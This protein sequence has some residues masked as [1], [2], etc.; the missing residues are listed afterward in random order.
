MTVVAVA[1]RYT[2]AYLFYGAFFVLVIAHRGSKWTAPLRWRFLQLSGALSYCLYLVHVSIGD[3]YES[4]LRGRGIKMESYLGPSGA[5]AFR[6][7]VIL[8]LSFGVALVSRKYVEQPCLALK[9]R[10]SHD[11][12]EIPS[13]TLQVRAITDRWSGAAG[14][15]TPEPQALTE[16][17]LTAEEVLT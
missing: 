13:Q 10:F 15:N 3:G 17:A 4:I 9:D 5:V 12:H 14:A 8:A 7:I 2:Q 1:L 11:R 6:A 16:E